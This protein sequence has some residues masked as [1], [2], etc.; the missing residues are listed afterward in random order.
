MYGSFT[1]RPAPS[2]LTRTK[3]SVAIPPSRVRARHRQGMHI[4]MGAGVYIGRIGGLAAA[5]GIGAAVFIGQGEASAE[6]ATG[7]GAAEYSSSSYTTPST[8]SSPSDHK[9]TEAAV[10][11]SGET[12]TRAADP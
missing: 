2:Q 10:G 4:G 12:E 5:L 8:S 3:Q 1:S 6:P 7:S 9:K 11:D